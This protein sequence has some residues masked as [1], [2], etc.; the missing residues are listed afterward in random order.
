HDRSSVRWRVRF[1]SMRQQGT[2][3]PLHKIRW[4]HPSRM[5]KIPPRYLDRGRWELLRARP[6][7]LPSRS[8]AST[9][10]TRPHN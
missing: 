4:M 2:H 7:R 3:L 1:R 10:S 9:R 5:K 6:G 8:P